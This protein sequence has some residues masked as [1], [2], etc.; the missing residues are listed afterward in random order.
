[1]KYGLA[2]SQVA[3]VSALARD[4]SLLNMDPSHFRPNLAGF[5]QN[6]LH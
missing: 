1:M 2:E 6:K 4:L 3:S 5:A